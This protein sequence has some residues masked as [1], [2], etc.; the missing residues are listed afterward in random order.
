MA[1]SISTTT[2]RSPQKLEYPSSIN[3]TLPSPSTPRTFHSSFDFISEPRDCETLA[4]GY[5]VGSHILTPTLEHDLRRLDLD[6][7]QRTTQLKHRKLDRTESISLPTTPTEQ[8]SPS[9]EHKYH[10]LMALKDSMDTAD[11]EQSSFSFPSPTDY[12]NAV[13]EPEHQSPTSQIIDESTLHPK[14]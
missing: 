2:P 14:R 9:Y 3:T 10:R 13:S 6:S 12:M 5:Q 1:E 7:N 4:T 8:L 11:E